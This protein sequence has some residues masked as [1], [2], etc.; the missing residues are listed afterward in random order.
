MYKM[1]PSKIYF[2]QQVGKWLL[3][4]ACVALCLFAVIGV[5]SLFTTQSAMRV[6]NVSYTVGALGELD[7]KNG[8]LLPVTED[9]N[10]IVSGFIPCTAIKVYPT[11]SQP[12]NY[13]LWY[14]DAD[15]NYITYDSLDYDTSC[16]FENGYIPARQNEDGAYYVD[17]NGKVMATEYVRIVLKPASGEDFSNPVSAWIKIITTYSDV[18]K[19]YTTRSPQV[20]HI[21][22]AVDKGE[23]DTVP[24]YPDFVPAT[25]PADP[26]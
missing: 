1:H 10:S 4:A 2:W 15:K 13:E 23:V 7:G 6:T 17:A 9:T 16:I 25:N 26:A 11:F 21:Q 12:C 18:L 5:A 8:V 20:N 3:I 14:Y 19:V 24:A 22:E